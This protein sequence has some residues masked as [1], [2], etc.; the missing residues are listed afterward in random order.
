MNEVMNVAPRAK[1]Q[2]GPVAKLDALYAYGSD[3]AYAAADKLT[4]EMMAET[5]KY[6]NVQEPKTPEQARL[7]AE[8]AEGAVVIAREWLG[9]VKKQYGEEEG[10]DWKRLWAEE[11]TEAAKAKA[12]PQPEPEPEAKPEPEPEEARPQPSAKA[13]LLREVRSWDEVVV[14]PGTSELEALTYVPGL[15]GDIVEWILKGAHRPNRMMALGVAVTVIGTL[16]G[17]RVMAP[18]GSAT[19]LYIVIVAASSRGKD[20]PL[21][22]GKALMH[23]VGARDLIGPDE[24]VSGPGLWRRIKRSPLLI[25][26]IDE[27]GDEL[28]KI[29]FQDGKGGSGG[30]RYVVQ[31]VAMLKKCYNAWEIFNTPEKA[32]GDESLELP[33]VA[34]SIVGAATPEAF[35]ASFK[36][37]DLQS[38]FVNRFMILPLKGHQ[39]APEQIPP[40][41]ADVPPKEL[42]EAL[43]GLP[44]QTYH[45]GKLLDQPFKDG[46][47]VMQLPER[48]P[49]MPWGPGAEEVYFSFSRKLDGLEETDPARAALSL[50]GCENA[51][52][53][54]TIVAI[55][56]GSPTVDRKDIEWAIKFAEHSIETALS[57]IDKYMQDYL[58]FPKMCAEVIAKI[59]GSADF[60][61]EYNLKRDFRN[62][63]KTGFELDT[64]IKHL[65][66]ERRI[67]EACKVEGGRG[68]AVKGY[69]I[70]R[71]G[72][73]PEA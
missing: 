70:V 34:M 65:K 37:S 47:P 30:N 46:K 9:R 39:K 41:G 59:E 8:L 28:A 56:R 40:F 1:P 71:P 67:I 42:V 26:F 12:E 48:L 14:P 43:K 21:K 36:P 7:K 19:H 66:G 15:V 32:E 60:R 44:R 58:A 54:A 68:A 73:D 51:A 17:R 4:Y 24:F 18:N 2:A 38:G 49:P 3:E 23:A 69:A 53:L 6:L 11:W 50:R 5:A 31:L 27:M 62:K 13:A 33:W 25:W 10:E 22:A 35:F 72:P 55:G 61:S 52:R 64:V 16:I 45:T 29:N 63:M 20:Y 57:D